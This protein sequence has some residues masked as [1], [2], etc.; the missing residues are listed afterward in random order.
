MQQDSLLYKIALTCIKGVGVLNARQL[1]AYCGGVE[2]I[3]QEK[4][5]VLEKIPGIGPETA[6]NILSKSS[7]ELA[8]EELKFVEKYK[9]GVHYYQ[10]S[11][12]PSRLKECTDAP[13]VFYS[14]GK[15]DFNKQHIISMV[16][17]R[18]ATRYG[19]QMTDAFVRELAASY[20]DAIVISGLAYGIDIHAHK[21]ALENGL[22][23]Y[24]VLGS[25]LD[26]IYPSVH[27][28]IARQIVERGA[29][30]SEYRSGS[31][32]DAQNFVKRNR[33]VAGMC[34]SLV[35]VESGIKG[36]SLITAN[37]ALSYNRDIFAF[38]GKVGEP[39]SEGCNNL[40]KTNR[41]GLIE[42]FSDLE[43]QMGWEKLGNKSNSKKPK[44]KTTD[45]E[46]KLMD[47][48]RETPEA[49]LNLLAK[50]SHMDMGTFHT[51]LF[52]MELKGLIQKLPGNVFTVS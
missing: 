33:I 43:Y 31:K 35:V 8:Q 10:D 27:S 1:V 45:E 14:K 23:T 52:E 2:A 28:S 18:N 21:A 12:Y 41:A 7:I 47:L 48:I 51:L 50:L 32:P 11:S 22:E 3:F 17:T 20:P 19:K 38:P 9:I 5:S 25:G 16:G 39:V 24:A 40:I 44:I 49:D 37:L 15:T 34:D 46:Q 13:L 26:K 29:I 42:S 6:R 30:L 4:K 36:G